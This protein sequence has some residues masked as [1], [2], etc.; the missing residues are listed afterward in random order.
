MDGFFNFLDLSSDFRTELLFD[1]RLFHFH[2][3]LADI[4]VIIVD[5]HRLRGL[6]FVIIEVLCIK[7]V[8]KILHLLFIFSWL[9]T[10]KGRESSWGFSISTDKVGLSSR[11]KF[12]HS[13]LIHNDFLLIFLRLNH[14]LFTL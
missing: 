2:D 10:S 1:S 8:L 12:L 4:V 3:R 9:G 6:F 11:F 14:G 7:L 5:H 13:D